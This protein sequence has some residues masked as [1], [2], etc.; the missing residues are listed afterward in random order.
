MD[1]K[2]INGTEGFLDFPVEVSNCQNEESVLEC[3]SKKYLDN[4]L[5]E[6]GCIPHHLRTYYKTVRYLSKFE[7]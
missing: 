7:S 5:N 2:E 4:G 1:V 6:C 3:K